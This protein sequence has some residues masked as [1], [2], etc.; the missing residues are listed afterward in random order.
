MTG[1]GGGAAITKS[2]CFFYSDKVFGFV[3]GFIYGF[4]SGIQMGCCSSKVD[5][6]PL[7]IR[8]RERKELLKAAADQR[9]AFAA[10]HLSYFLSLK[11]VGEALRKF[12]DEE[13]VVAA[14]S[15]STTTTTSSPVVTLHPIDDDDEEYDEE[16]KVKE[17][18]KFSRNLDGNKVKKPKSKSKKS[19]HD[20]DGNESHL[21]LSSDS[22]S[23]SDSDDLSHI[24]LHNNG[25]ENVEYNT[26]GG[27]GREGLHSYP[28]GYPGGYSVPYG[29]GMNQDQLPPGM[30]WGQYPAYN[31]YFGSNQPY[32]AWAPPT[33]ENPNVN[34]R[35]TNVYFMKRS[36]PVMKT[37]IHETEPATNGFSSSFYSYPF[38]NEGFYGFP[39]GQPQQRG[40]EFEGRK[41]SGPADPPPPPSP[42]ASTWDFLNP[43]DAFDSGY[44]QGYYSQ[45]GRHGS[46]VSS[47][48]SAEVRKR[49]G[50]PDLE[51]ETENEVYREVEK[52]K[53]VDQDVKRS[54]SGD[55]SSGSRGVPFH[56][57]SEDIPERGRVPL[58]KSTLGGP[59]TVPLHRNYDG[60]SGSVP[61][62]SSEQHF[63]ERS[64]KGVPSESNEATGSIN[65]SDEMSSSETVLSSKSPEDVYV[66][67]KE[68]SFEVDETSKVD[69]ESSKLS[70]LTALSPHGS[71][72]L[73]EVVAEIKDEFTVASS[74]GKDV[75]VLLEVGKLPY[76]PSFF[77]VILSRILYLKSP[78]LPSSY[79]PSMGSIK[80]AAKTTKLAKSYF[81]DL[82]KDIEAKPGNLSS[83]L[84]QLYAWE[85]KLYKEV[86]VEEKLR[87]VYEKKCKQLRILDEKGAESN[88][89]DAIRASIR[90][91]LTKLNV[92]MKTIDAISSRIHKLRDEELQPQ[93]ANLIHGLIR[94]WKSMLGCH[95]KQ[96]QA[97]MESKLR[98]LKANTSFQGD[99]S[100]RASHELEMELRAWSG[101]FNDWI[102]IQKSYV[103]S[104]NEWLLRCLLYEPEETPDGPVPF[105]PGRLGAPP[106]FVICNDWYQ[107]METISE[108]RVANAMNN[109]ASILRELWEKQS[110][111]QRQ[112][113][114]AQDLSMDFKNRIKTLQMERGRTAH[115][116]QTVPN[117]SGVSIVPSENGISPFDD[118]KVDLDLV[119][120]R[121]AEERAKHKDAIKIVHDAAS[122][123]V[124][125]GLVPIFKALESF[126]SEALKA[127]KQVRLRND[128][129]K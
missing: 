74:Y 2:V 129:E 47:P 106:I 33:Y 81:G 34:Y 57:S 44:L 20:K 108:I 30:Y 10:A 88:K 77:R 114:K 8:C 119:R 82:W 53:K 35:H 56:K 49:E 97:I 102:N 78:S 126:S 65:L 79:Q 11:D 17:E 63:S 32:Q 18:V 72:D 75:L 40:R 39:M 42:K 123:S 64:S 105:S 22:D 15:S 43:F 124:Q 73:R 116:K 13:L 61:M 87:V 92:C 66:T 85:K 48:D 80:L 128:E 23:D 4:C 71:R 31:N 67:K 115:E 36:S 68:V 55:G 91:L 112:R 27:G 122:T 26:G 76:Q 98:T 59:K 37:V 70:S 1:D 7:V 86:K 60:I 125:G 41:P 14:S 103:E 84:E 127:H 51:E 89:I 95:Q 58:W 38:E 110:E 120:K 100:S 69:V 83:T 99:S 94:M 21:H 54:Y 111:E 62:P 19:D 16:E 121:L 90:N 101:R 52:G 24:H 45:D 29:Y 9:Y 28:D 3:F 96:F 12:V 25:D 50:I 46:S 6:L 118:L 107:A 5:D 104:L 93:V 113:V 117:K 109:F